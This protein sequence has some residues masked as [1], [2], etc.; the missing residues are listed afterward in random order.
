MAD[1]DPDTSSDQ[2]VLIRQ[3]ENENTNDSESLET[4]HTYEDDHDDQY[5][6]VNSTIDEPT[7]D[8]TMA[9]LD[10]EMELKTV[11]HQI[12]SAHI[13]ANRIAANT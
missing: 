3:T 7:T 13:A 6:E 2:D 9:M 1:L 11:G 5:E 4:G 8:P 10:K 12:G